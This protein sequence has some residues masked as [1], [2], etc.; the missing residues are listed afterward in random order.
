[1]R[2]IVFLAIF[3]VLFGGIFGQEI[4]DFESRYFKQRYEFKLSL[5]TANWNSN[6]DLFIFAREKGAQSYFKANVIMGEYR[7]LPTGWGRLT[8]FWDPFLDSRSPAD[9][10]F[11]IYAV[12]LK[13]TTAD[14]RYMSVGQVGEV[15]FLSKLKNVYYEMAGNRLKNGDVLALPS[16]S[17]EV[18]VFQDKRLISKNTVSVPAFDTIA[19]D[20]SPGSGSLKLTSALSG[21]LYAIDDSDFSS[22]DSYQL[23]PGRYVV[24][25]K[26][27]QANTDYPALTA[28]TTVE[29]KQD[30]Q[31][32]HFFEFPHGILNLETD[33]AK[34]V[35][36]IQG[37]SYNW[38]RGMM[39]KPG[40]VT[41]LATNKQNPTLMK[42]NLSSNLGIRKG[43]TTTHKF[44]FRDKWGTLRIIY[45]KEMP[46][47]TIN[48][49]SV[50]PNTEFDLP[51]GTYRVQ[52]TFSGS[53]KVESGPLEV[54][55]KVVTTFNLDDEVAKIGLV[56]GMDG[57][58]FQYYTMHYFTPKSP[59]ARS[60]QAI[61]ISGINMGYILAGRVLF[62]RGYAGLFNNFYGIYDTEER[63]LTI[64]MDFFSLGLSTG[65]APFRGKVML[66][67]TID[68]SFS[69]AA[70]ILD[71]IDLNGVKYRF[72]TSFIEEKESNK[73]ETD[74]YATPPVVS[75]TANLELKPWRGFGLYACAGIKSSNITSGAW[76]KDSDVEAWTTNTSLPKPKKVQD[77]MLPENNFSLNGSLLD[78]GFGF[79]IIF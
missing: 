37:K 40:S 44:N 13:F 72:V 51:E 29:I 32:Q 3:L 76:Y 22:Q 54:I 31:S 10:E 9:Y 63:R 55:P 27:E 11:R 8:V 33:L 68:G 70:P 28:Q 17:Y 7:N 6:Y 64:N 18:N 79:R 58:V 2:K 67:G 53:K 75:A 45:S 69:V 23:T 46:A 48:G 49:V 42:Q 35:Y 5:P 30:Q 43:G 1:M 50:A 16:G 47:L 4:R 41:V 57:H 24:H 52:A 14:Y 34:T 38:V 39:L 25:A 65:L 60:S 26:A 59:D 62:L 66:Y 20:L 36:V 74:S 71:T 12:P 61:S 77:P 21:T 73:R 19:A 78:I 56:S 15:K